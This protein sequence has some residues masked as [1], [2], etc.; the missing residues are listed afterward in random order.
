MIFHDPELKIAFENVQASLEKRKKLIDNMNSDINN[1]EKILKQSCAQS[2]TIDFG[3]DFSI[4][5]D[6]SA[7]HLRCLTLYSNETTT[8]LRF[9]MDLPLE[10][11]ITRSQH[12]P[13]FIRQ[14]GMK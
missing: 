3:K 14:I 13:E 5:W 1:L 4:V 7:G 9:F 2:I 11:R 12:L 10:E 6:L 8:L